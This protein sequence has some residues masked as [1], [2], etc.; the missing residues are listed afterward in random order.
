MNRFFLNLIFVILLSL[1]GCVSTQ[2]N[3]PPADTAGIQEKT[4]FLNTQ[5]SEK[6]TGT[7]TTREN[8]LLE[9]EADP[10]TMMTE[11]PDS[12]SETSAVKKEFGDWNVECDPAGANCAAILRINN[13]AGKQVFVLMVQEVELEDSAS[14]PAVTAWLPLGV[15][16]PE[17]AKVYVEKHKE[18]FSLIAQYCTSQGCIAESDTPDSLVDALREQNSSKVSVSIIRF[19]ASKQ[20]TFSFTQSGFPEAYRYIMEKK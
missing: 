19:P 7:T 11:S 5:K 9:T 6:P 1:Y 10:E 18:Y 13:R 14:K 16:L 8:A 3:I 17:H 20:I 15:Y 12:V 2:Q 4:T